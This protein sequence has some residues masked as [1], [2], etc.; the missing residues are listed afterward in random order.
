MTRSTIKFQLEFPSAVSERLDGF[1]KALMR[2]E[3]PPTRYEWV[4]SHAGRLALSQL[5][6]ANRA[7]YYRKPLKVLNKELHAA[8]LQATG[9]QATG[10]PNISRFRARVLEEALALYAAIHPLGD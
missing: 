8:Y 3:K 6:E 1:A 5:N 7:Q 2:C 10:R 9:A 4:T